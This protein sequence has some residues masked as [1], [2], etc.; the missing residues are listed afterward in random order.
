MDCYVKKLLNRTYLLQT[1]L[2]RIL[3]QITWGC[4]RKVVGLINL[5]S[6]SMNSGMKSVV[7]LE[8]HDTTPCNTSTIK[9]KILKT[10]KKQYVFRNC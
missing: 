2:K 8:L 3:G 1:Q 6:N 9:T 4:T 5:I 10:N 7:W